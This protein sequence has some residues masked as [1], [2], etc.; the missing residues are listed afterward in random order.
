MTAYLNDHLVFFL[1][2]FVYL[3]LKNTEVYKKRRSF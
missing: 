2:V 3:S 1:N